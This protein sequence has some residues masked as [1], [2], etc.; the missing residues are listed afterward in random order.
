MANKPKA[1]WQ[2]G[3]KAPLVFSLV[4]ALIAGVV[5]TF[6]AAGGTENGLRIDIGLIAFGVAFIVSLVVISL[7]IMAGRENDSDFGTGSGVNRSS[8][9]PDRRASDRHTGEY[10]QKKGH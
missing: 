4:M 6:A 8:K 5:A 7:M 3:I 9:H 1:P 2:Q 10:G